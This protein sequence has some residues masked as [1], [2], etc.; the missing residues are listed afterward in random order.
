MGPRT[1][2]GDADSDR[3]RA[4]GP[5]PA[6]NYPPDSGWDRKLKDTPWGVW[7]VCLF[8]LGAL[9][10]VAAA[11]HDSPTVVDAGPHTITVDGIQITDQCNGHGWRVFITRT[12]QA[13][14]MSAVPDRTCP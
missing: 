14:A 9:V 7:I 12:E 3:A 11:L 6:M 8:V 4:E 13:T 10:G 1:F 5:P 2:T